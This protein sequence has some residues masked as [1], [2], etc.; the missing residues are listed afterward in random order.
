MPIYEYEC[1]KCG[2]RFERLVRPSTTP[3]DSTIACPSCAGE[4]VRQLLSLFAV[5]SE[6]TRQLHKDQGRRLAAKDLREEKHAERQAE[7]HHY[8]EHDH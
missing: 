8:G 2:H 6:G 3:T 1:E 4:N 5:S 7:L